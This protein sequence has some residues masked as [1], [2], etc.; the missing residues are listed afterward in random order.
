MKTMIA[1]SSISVFFIMVSGCMGISGPDIES[2]DRLVGTPFE[3]SFSGS[4]Y[5]EEEA[6]TI[7]FKLELTDFQFL[8]HMKAIINW[9]DEPPLDRAGSYHNEGDTFTLRVTDGERIDQTSS[10]VNSEY[11]EGRTYVYIEGDLVQNDSI[12]RP[13]TFT[14]ELTLLHCGD[15]YPYYYHSEA[16]RE[17]D[18]GNEYRWTVDYRYV[19]RN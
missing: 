7:L 13:L 12:S 15:Q 18:P 3:D 4:G 6:T 9:E 19:D 10:N 11:C 1:L 5:L 2:E 17:E 16:L 14:V 8:I